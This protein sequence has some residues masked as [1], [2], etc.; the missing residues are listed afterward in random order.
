M[1][2]RSVRYENNGDQDVSANA[3]VLYHRR[4]DLPRI[5]YALGEAAAN[6][7]AMITVATI[8]LSL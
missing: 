1:A 3:I 6:S 5:D 8:L 7:W 2:C 4:H